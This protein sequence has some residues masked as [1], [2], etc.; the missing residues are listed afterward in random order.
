M[1]DAVVGGHAKPSESDKIVRF[2][3]NHFLWIIFGTLLPKLTCTKA[4]LL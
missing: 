2:Y 1:D 4:R 3:S